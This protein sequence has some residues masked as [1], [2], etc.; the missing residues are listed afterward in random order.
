LL[1]WRKGKC[2]AD[3]TPPHNIIGKGIHNHLPTGEGA[4]T[5]LELMTGSQILLKD[6]PINLARREAGKDSADSIWLWGQ[7]PAATMETIPAMFGINGSVICAVDLIRGIGKMA[8]LDCPKVKGATGYLD[9]DYD[10]KAAAA[11]SSLKTSD[12]IFLHVEAP[13]EAGHEGNAE[14]K[15]KAIERFDEKVVGPVWEAL[16]KSGEPYKL[17]IM[18]D[19]PTPVAKRT[20]TYDPIL[21]AMVESDKEPDPS[22]QGKGFT[23]AYAT[24]TGLVVKKAH[25]L[26]QHMTEKQR[27]W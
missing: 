21:F 15:I 8:G 11:I 20:H 18:P 19:H 7:G 6:H 10:A 3:T 22:K 12:Y 27:Q 9:T 13:D 2:G 26:M 17:L 14:E 1:V 16:E 23:E 24:A 5:L 4:A 25:L